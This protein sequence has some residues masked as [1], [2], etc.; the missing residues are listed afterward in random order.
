MGLWPVPCWV[1][2]TARRRFLNAGWTAF[3][4]V[5]VWRVWPTSW[6]LWQPD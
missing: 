5:V 2:V 3:L 4:N 1:H 6:R